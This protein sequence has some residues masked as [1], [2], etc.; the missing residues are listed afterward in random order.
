MNPE[1]R[2]HLIVSPIPRGVIAAV[3][4]ERLRDPADLALQAPSLARCA[5][6]LAERHHWRSASRFL[7]LAC[8][9]L[10]LAAH[11]TD[12]IRS[13]FGK[14]SVR[15]GSRVEIEPARRRLADSLRAMSSSSMCGEQ[16]LGLSLCLCSI[17][18]F[19]AAEIAYG[20]ALL[21]PSAPSGKS[22]HGKPER[23]IRQAE[24]ATA[25]R[26]EIAHRV[27]GRQVALI[28]AAPL[29]P[30]SIV[31]VRDADLVAQTKFLPARSRRVAGARYG[32]SYLN[33]DMERRACSERAY[34]EEFEQAHKSEGLWLVTK[35]SPRPELA[36]IA[37]PVAANPDSILGSAMIG[38]RAIADLLAMRP[39]ELILV[40]FESYGGRAPHDLSSW[41]QT[42]QRSRGVSHSK[43]WYCRAF[44]HHSV[45]SNR[46]YLKTVSQLANVTCDEPTRRS[47]EM[48]RE[49][50]AK[51][52]EAKFG[53]PFRETD[54]TE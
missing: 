23:R 1:L 15:T 37:T 18:S 6:E 44:G 12:E 3:L 40:G 28:G 39:R 34:R 5:S 2:H 45:F 22:R 54:A 27:H 25:I 8:H 38:Q 20:N 14:Q 43:S 24:Q 49:D 7:H 33:R 48:T 16:W 41:T 11:L 50:Y 9:C 42:D 53:F 36:H 47:L 10:G 17:G 19:V 31:G 32:L 21:A 46:D 13:D 35:A 29:D 52:M 51:V 26:Q 30:G 4:R